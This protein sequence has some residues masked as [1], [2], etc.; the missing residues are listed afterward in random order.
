MIKEIIKLGP[1]AGIGLLIGII[2]AEWIDNENSQA[3]TFL[4]VIFVL[5]FTLLG[6]LF[7]RNK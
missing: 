5:V 1:G 4:V 7:L 3:Y 2:V 6:R